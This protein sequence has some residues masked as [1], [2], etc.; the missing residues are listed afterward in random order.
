MPVIGLVGIF[1]AGQ[2]DLVGIDDDD[3]VAIVHMRGEGGLVLAAQAVGDERGKTAD[4]QTFGVDQHPLL[5]HFR[6]LLGES[7]H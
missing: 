6:R 4:D 1:L 5:H 7:C 3:V 2:H